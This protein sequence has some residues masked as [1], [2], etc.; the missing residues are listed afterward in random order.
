MAD[1][2]NKDTPPRADITGAEVDA[3]LVKGDAAAGAPPGT[4]QPYDLVA[5]DRI[6]RGRMPV[7]DRLNSAG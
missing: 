5:R 7:L 2:P 3:L 1:E 6:V 4:P